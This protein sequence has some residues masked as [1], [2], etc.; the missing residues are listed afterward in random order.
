MAVLP[1]MEASTWA[2]SVVGTWT[3]LTPRMYVAAVK[4]ARSP[5]AP[6]PTA[7]TVELRSRP[8]SRNRSQVEAA[9]SRVLARSPSGRSTVV[10]SKPAARRLAA[11]VSPWSF[12]MPGSV[13]RAILRPTLRRP[14][15]APAWPSTPGPTRIR[16]ER[17]PGLTGIS[18]LKACPGRLPALEVVEVPLVVPA[19]LLDAV[20]RELLQEGPGG[21]E[22]HHGL[23][24]PPRRGH[25][26][27]VT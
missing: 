27:H 21:D 2:R 5:T 10:T 25:R 14:S 18:I 8:A 23:A 4:P 13:T 22:R 9:T 20:A 3:K 26:A 24:H 11:T 16:Y 12:R 17:A 6:P 1:P 15:S 19:D 7:T